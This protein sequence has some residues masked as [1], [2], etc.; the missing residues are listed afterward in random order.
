M[1]KIAVCFTGFLRTANYTVDSFLRFFGDLYPNVDIFIHTWDK[2]QNKVLYRA[3]KKVLEIFEKHNINSDDYRQHK[4]LLAPKVASDTLEV[5]ND[6]Y[7]KYNKNKIVFVGI[8]KFDNLSIPPYYRTQEYLWYNIIEKVI[9]H[10]KLFNFKYDVVVKTR[11]DIVIPKYY[12]LKDE[13]DNFL[14]D[15]NGFYSQRYNAVNSVSDVF[16]MARSEIMKI[17]YDFGLADAP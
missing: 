8:E 6:L 17:A 16:H 2:N 5:L 12:S 11:A 1:T 9:A 3:S 10:E 15:P 13:L 14:L 4:Y 7:K